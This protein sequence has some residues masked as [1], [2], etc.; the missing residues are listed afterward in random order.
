MP[1][2]TASSITAFPKK[3]AVR[4]QLHLPVIFHWGDAEQYTH[5]GFT[6]EVAKDGAFILSS[7]LPP[8]GSEVRIEVLIPS[9]N[10]C[11][12]EF[13]IEC[14]A[15]IT[16]IFEEIECTGFS[17]DGV[18]S[19]DHLKRFESHKRLDGNRIHTS[20]DFSSGI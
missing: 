6:K 2:H 3:Q 14:S 12:G 20:P 5:G 4:F 13:R 8:V 17:V 10:P 7:V 1:L 11:G 19:D 18:F 15:T 16:K 9:P